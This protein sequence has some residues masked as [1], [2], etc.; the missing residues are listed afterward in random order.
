MRCCRFAPASSPAL[1]SPTICLTF[2]PLLCSS[3]ASMQLTASLRLAV[4][5]CRDSVPM[6]PHLIPIRRRSSLERDINGGEGWRGDN[7]LGVSEGSAGI[8]VS[9]ARACVCA[10]VCVCA[11][12]F[13]TAAARLQRYA[14]LC[15]IPFL[16]FS[17]FIHL[18]CC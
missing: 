13:A 2:P 8:F 17:H 14:V 6:E 4:S 7:T 11:R 3:I 10:C 18:T 1:L 5:D 15:S 12:Y 16:D 9:Y